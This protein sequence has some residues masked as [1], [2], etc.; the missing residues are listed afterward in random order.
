MGNHELAPRLGLKR[1]IYG[2]AM[3]RATSGGGGGPAWVSRGTFAAEIV[4]AALVAFLLARLVWAGYPP[5]VEPP[6]A[7]GAPAVAGA[8]VSL[9]AGDPF[10]RGASTEAADATAAAPPTTLNLVLAGVRASGAESADAEPADAAWDAGATAI[11]QTPDNQQRLY[12]VGDEIVPGVTLAAVEA[13]RVVILRDGQRESVGF[14]EREGLIGSGTSA[15]PEASAEASAPRAAVAAAALVEGVTAFSRA[16]GGVVV[17]PRGD[18]A[19]FADAGLEPLDVVLAINGVPLDGLE[20]WS[21]L[22]AGLGPGTAVVADIERAGAPVT[23][24]F[25][26]E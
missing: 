6:P 17:S 15:P 19:A 13:Q 5:F 9:K 16:D 18:G 1:A 7:L 3:S 20:G 12:R 10:R 14:R 4:G 21:R 8:V 22:V 25:V 26:L 11:I 24:R 2:G 23:V